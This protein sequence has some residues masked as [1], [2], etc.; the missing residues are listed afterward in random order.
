MVR[1]ESPCNQPERGDVAERANIKKSAPA[2]PV[3]QPE[4]DKGENKIG[5]ANADRLQQRGFSAKPGKFEYARREI[6]N[7][8]D[9]RHL[10]EKRNQDGEHDRLSKGHS[11]QKSP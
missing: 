4:A 6:Q 9:A 7:R 3:N 1:K 2:Q 11:P 5:D 8:I 10:I